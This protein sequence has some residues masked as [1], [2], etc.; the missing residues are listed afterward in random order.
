MKSEFFILNI[1]HA[2]AISLGAA[3]RGLW[4][5]VAAT[6]VLFHGC[7]QQEQQRKRG[8]SL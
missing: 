7:A 4:E 2:L 5:S 1:R 8:V 6:Q 3:L